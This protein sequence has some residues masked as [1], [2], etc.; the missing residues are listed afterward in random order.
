MDL[1]SSSSN[2]S[3]ESRCYEFRGN[4]N[5]GKWLF[6]NKRKRAPR[7]RK[8]KKVETRGE[9]ARNQGTERGA[10]LSFKSIVNDPPPFQH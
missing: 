9:V 3:F 8:V 2:F 6:V 5:R 7:A 4:F 1:P 10:P